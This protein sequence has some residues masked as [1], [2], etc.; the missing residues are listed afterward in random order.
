MMQ[1]MLLGYGGV[2][3]EVSGG[4]AE[5]TYNGKKIHVFTSS[6]ALSVSGGPVSLEVFMVGGGAGGGGYCGGGGGGGGVVTHAASDRDWE[7]LT[8]KAPLEV[9]T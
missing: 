2:S 1:Q 8:L 3:L 6:G 7:T 9:N 4:D 5:F